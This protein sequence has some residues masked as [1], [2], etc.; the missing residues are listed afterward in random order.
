MMIAPQSIRRHT[1]AAVVV[2]AAAQLAGC[3]STRLDAQWS[4]P[5]LAPNSLRGARVLVA[6][7]AHDLVLKQ[8]CLDQ[9]SAEVVARGGTAVPAPDIAIAGPGRAAGNEAYLDAARQA[10]AKGIIS[11]AVTI[12]DVGGSGGSGVSIGIGGFGI[13]GGSV[14]GGVG[15][16]VPVGSSAPPNN[17]YA[18]SSRVSDAG[19]RLLYTAKASASPSADVNAQFAELTKA[20][21]GGADKAQL[22]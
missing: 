20:L 1:A 15:V 16:S 21:F 4:D 18:M 6:C 8:I 14:R 9:L 2:I 12:A 3:A 10:Q 17:G 19:G 11:H 13:G 22:F 7:E 5:Q